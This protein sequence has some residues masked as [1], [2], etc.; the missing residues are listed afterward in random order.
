MIGFQ[1]YLKKCSRRF[2]PRQRTN[3]IPKG[4]IKLHIRIS[5]LITTVLFKEVKALAIG[6]LLGTVFIEEHIQAILPDERNVAA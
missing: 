2:Y 3:L 4:H 6:V 5:P 1:K